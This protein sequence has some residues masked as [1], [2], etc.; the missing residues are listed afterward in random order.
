[1]GLFVHLQVSHPHHHQVVSAW[2]DD[3]T[4]IIML[5]A[6]C[7]LDYGVPSDGG[8]P[9]LL[10]R[11][12]TSDGGSPSPLTGVYPSDGGWRVSS[13][14]AESDAVSLKRIGF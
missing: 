10:S 5:I 11:V 8:S 9:P 4:Q 3:F 12:L 13:S 7:P 1:M 6:G 14:S 2:C